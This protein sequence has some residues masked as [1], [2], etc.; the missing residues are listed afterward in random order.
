MS[1]TRRSERL[2]E[3]ARSQKD[4]CMRCQLKETQIC[5]KLEALYQQQNEFISISSPTDIAIPSVR[6]YVQQRCSEYS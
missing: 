4:M 1:H 2:N 5:H 6:E 3:S